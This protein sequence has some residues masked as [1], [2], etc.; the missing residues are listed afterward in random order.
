MRDNGKRRMERG[1]E[2]RENGEE[3]REREGNINNLNISLPLAHK[4]PR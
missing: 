4:R 3:M 2:T 1:E